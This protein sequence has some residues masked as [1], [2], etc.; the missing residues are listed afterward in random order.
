LTHLISQAHAETFSILK[1]NM[2]R[3]FGTLGYLYH[4][5]T[6]AIKLAPLKPFGYTTFVAIE[7]VSK[8]FRAELLEEAKEKEAPQPLQPPK[9]QTYRTIKSFFAVQ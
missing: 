5:Q 7:E 6:S 1:F 8:N 4:T 9:A 3:L 2:V